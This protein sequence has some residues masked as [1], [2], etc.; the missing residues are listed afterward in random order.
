MSFTAVRK[1][2]AL[3]VSGKN[4]DMLKFHEEAFVRN[5]NTLLDKNHLSNAL[6]MGATITSFTDLG[7]GIFE[8]QYTIEAYNPSLDEVTGT[9]VT[10]P[11]Q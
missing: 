3:P 7:K 2:T 1:G 10:H 11:A 4:A 5:V 8:F 6:V 9:F